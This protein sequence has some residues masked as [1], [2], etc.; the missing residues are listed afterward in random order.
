MTQ[1]LGLLAILVVVGGGALLLGIS[2]AMARE[3]RHERSRSRE[4][5]DSDDDTVIAS[6]ASTAT[7][8]AAPDLG[9]SCGNGGASWDSGSSSSCSSD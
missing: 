3:A 7:T 9:A 1:A 6:T 4:E 5:G 8:A 2:D